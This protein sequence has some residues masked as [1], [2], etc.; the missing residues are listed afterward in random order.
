MSYN[1]SRYR[2]ATTLKQVQ[3]F[4]I[5]DSVVNND[6]GSIVATEN[7]L[8]DGETG[9][10]LVS[11]TK[12][13]FKRPIYQVNYP[14][15]WLKN[16]MGAAYHNIDAVFKNISFYQGKITVGL[17]PTEQEEYFN[18]GDELYN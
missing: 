3:E 14:S 18:S 15:H 6:K 2:H 10:V 11:K 1:E 16:E 5:I 12:N 4:G 9:Q 13:E 17:T 7:L 8:Y